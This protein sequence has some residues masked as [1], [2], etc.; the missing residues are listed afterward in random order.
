[1]RCRTLLLCLSAGEFK[2]EARGDPVSRCRGLRRTVSS[3]QA[4]GGSME[5]KPA[6]DV[7]FYVGVPLRPAHRASSAME[8]VRYFE[9][10]RMDTTTL[11]IIVLVLLLLG[12]GWY[13]RGRWY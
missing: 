6:V 11:L 2:A 8:M 1:M 12:G 10:T 13:G 5:R 3:P 9:E 4:I 7:G